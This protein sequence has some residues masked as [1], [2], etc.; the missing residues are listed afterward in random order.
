MQRLDLHR[1]RRGIVFNLYTNP[2]E[3]VSI[4]IRHIPLRFRW[5][6]PEAGT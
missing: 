1:H 5:E 4:G 6:K 2:Q 3:D